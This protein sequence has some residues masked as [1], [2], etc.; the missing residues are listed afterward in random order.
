MLRLHYQSERKQLSK[1]RSVGKYKTL[2]AISLSNMVFCHTM[3]SKTH[4]IAFDMV[5]KL[6]SC[7]CKLVGT[8]YKDCVIVVSS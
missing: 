6:Y 2:Y 5:L 3:L 8:W 4:N 1:S 7:H